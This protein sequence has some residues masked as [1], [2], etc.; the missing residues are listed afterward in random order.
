MLP[1]DKIRKCLKIEYEDDDSVESIGQIYLPEFDS[2]VVFVIEFNKKINPELLIDSRMVKAIDNLF[3]QLNQKWVY[4]LANKHFNDITNS[5]TYGRMTHELSKKHNGNVAEANRELFNIFDV[6]DVK[7]SM[8][9]IQINIS[10]DQTNEKDIYS[11]IRFEIPWDFEHG[12]VYEFK[13]NKFQGI[14]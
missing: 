6:K 14:E 10:Q 1:I 11:S 12:L 7:N 4:E 3:E 13:N 5:T 2:E 9:L 8:K